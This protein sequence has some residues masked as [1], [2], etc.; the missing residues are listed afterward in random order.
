MAA[1]GPLAIFL[2]SLL[3]FPMMY[4]T[5]QAQTVH[6]ELGLFVVGA[7]LSVAFSAQAQPLRV[8]T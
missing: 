5:N 8:D 6:G 1:F 7:A 4:A 2:I 3:A